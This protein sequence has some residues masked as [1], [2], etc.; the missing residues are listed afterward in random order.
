MAWVLTTHTHGGR[1]FLAV[2]HIS[3]YLGLLCEIGLNLHPLVMEEGSNG[4][5]YVAI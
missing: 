3:F 1:S 2:S 5:S 4:T